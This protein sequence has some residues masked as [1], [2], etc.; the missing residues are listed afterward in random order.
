[1]CSLRQQQAYLFH[2]E[3]LPK[4]H[5]V[6]AFERATQLALSALLFFSLFCRGEGGGREGRGGW[7]SGFVRKKKKKRAICLKF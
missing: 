7:N 6:Q 1:M 4:T 2:R 5:R 3:V